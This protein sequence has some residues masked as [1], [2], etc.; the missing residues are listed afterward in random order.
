MTGL[1]RPTDRCGG[2]A[3]L[4]RA[5]AP[6]RRC[7]ALAAEPGRQPATRLSP[8][9]VSAAATFT[10]R[11]ARSGAL[12]AGLALAVVV[13]AGVLHLW[14][15]PRRPTIAWALTVL[16]A[17]TLVYLAL[18]FR[19]WGRGVV[20]VTPERLGLRIT[21][22][23]AAEVPRTAVAG[24]IAATWRDVPDHPDAAYVNATG[25][26]EPNVLLTFAAPVKVRVA[27]GLVTRQVARLGLRLDD[28]DAFVR[29]VTTPPGAD[30]AS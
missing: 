24:V 9:P 29:A 6:P 21:G 8:S 13:E 25:P 3:Q 12:T 10:Y 27:G 18:E 30:V 11:S 28:P 1:A 23:A 5:T 17:L 19:A 22:R 4:G 16:S 7:D 26:A 2:R 14:L 20:C 15:A